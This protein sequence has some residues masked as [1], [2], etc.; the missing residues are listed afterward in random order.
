MMPKGSRREV[1]AAEPLVAYR[2]PHRWILAPREA[3]PAQSGGL[4]IRPD[5]HYLITG[6]LD[7]YGSALAGYLMAEYAASVTVI[8][9]AAFPP[10]QEWDAWL[11]RPRG[12]DPT[13]R[14]I[15][16]AQA[17]HRLRHR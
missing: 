11:A 2:G 9:E 5:G 3:A 1:D 16:H 15:R 14:R 6:G 17:L 13:V 4:A 7:E 8:E 12:T 10:P